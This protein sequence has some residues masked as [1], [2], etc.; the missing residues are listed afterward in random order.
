MERTLLREK[1]GPMPEQHYIQ[2]GGGGS[3]EKKRVVVFR[4]QEKKRPAQGEKK[5]KSK[6][7]VSITAW[8]RSD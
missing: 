5:A 4:L 6:K 2:R 8:A 1:G 3:Q 7:G